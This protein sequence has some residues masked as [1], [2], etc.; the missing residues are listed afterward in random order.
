MCLSL[1]AFFVSLGIVIVS[2][3]RSLPLKTGGNWEIDVYRGGLAVKVGLEGS[4]YWD[5]QVMEA[6]ARGQIFWLPCSTVNSQ[7][8]EWCVVV[9]L[10]WFVMATAGT[11][12]VSACRL[13]RFAKPGLCRRC[14]YDVSTLA[15]PATCPECGTLN[16]A[17]E[18]ERHEQAARTRHGFQRDS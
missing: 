3:W 17:C 15:A 11:V 13:R 6:R 8:P 14:A 2:T 16:L 10:V 18:S 1:T 7:A 9:P 5:Y 12:V 4:A